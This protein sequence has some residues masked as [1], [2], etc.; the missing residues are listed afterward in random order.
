MSRD[1]AMALTAVKKVEGKQ[2]LKTT[3]FSSCVQSNH[4]L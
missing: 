4:F 2:I 1:V 3:V